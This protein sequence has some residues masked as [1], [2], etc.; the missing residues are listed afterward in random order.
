MNRT[1]RFLF[2]THPADGHL[3]PG[4]LIARALVAR[5]HQVRWYTGR[6]YRDVIEATGAGFEPMRTAIDPADL[7][8]DQRFPERA[9]LEGLDGLRFDLKHLFLD[10][11]PDQIM[12]L[13]RILAGYPA[14]ALVVDT[15]FAAAGMMH[16]LGGPPW[17]TYGITAL[18][19]NSRDTAPFGTGLPPGRSLPMRLR[20]RALNAYSDRVLMRDVQRHHQLIRARAG[21]PPTRTGVLSTPLSRYLYLHASTP[22]FEYPRSDLPPH[23][24][25]IGPLLPEPPA[26]VTPPAWWPQ[27]TGPEPVVLVNQGTVATD[28]DDLTAPS[29]RAL[30]GERLLVVATGGA[31]RDGLTGRVPQ[32]ARVESYV[33]FGALLPQVDVMVT[34]G[35]YGGVQFALAHGVPL[36][37]AGTTEDKPEVGDRVAWSGAGINLKVKSPTPD[38]IRAAV[39]AVLA[40]PRYRRNAERIR[41]DYRTH[42]APAEAA[43]MLEQLAVTRRP[44]TTAPP[45]ARAPRPAG[46]RVGHRLKAGE[47]A[48]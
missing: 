42:D 4:L 48:G 1:F 47:R 46:G 24:H 36:V 40:E 28:L 38:Q 20:N 25:F 9:G 6:R 21:L 13:R 3:N 22:A 41:D 33:P 8:P 35:G 32:N 14:D 18:T 27:L 15:G 34:N 23:V 17:A 12:D 2:A 37:V 44:V 26:D 29:L 19:V 45:I 31:G 7:G 11:V 39:R 30:A 16:E 10:D 43:L 5:G